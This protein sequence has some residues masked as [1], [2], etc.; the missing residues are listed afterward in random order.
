MRYILAWQPVES[1]GERTLAAYTAFRFDMED[2]ESVVYWYKL[3]IAT[4]LVSF[5]DSGSALAMTFRY[6]G[7]LSAEALVDT[8]WMHYICWDSIQDWRD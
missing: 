5:S 4:L 7:S 6:L 2:D 1:G 3:S 8:S